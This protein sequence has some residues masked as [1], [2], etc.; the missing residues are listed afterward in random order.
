MT[1]EDWIHDKFALNLAEKYGDLDRSDEK[2]VLEFIN[3]RRIRKQAI[4]YQKY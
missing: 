1:E 2:K 4:S 3:K